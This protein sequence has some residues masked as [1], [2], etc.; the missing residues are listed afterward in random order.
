MEMSRL[1][2]ILIASLAAVSFGVLLYIVFDYG[3]GY[4]FGAGVAAASEACGEQVVQLT[5]S[6]GGSVD[7]IKQL[8]ST[9]CYGGN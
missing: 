2:D 8:V 1:K 6:A 7:V 5:A 3:F 9:I 4:G